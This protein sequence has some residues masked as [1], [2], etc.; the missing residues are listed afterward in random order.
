MTRFWRLVSSISEGE[1]VQRLYIV[2]AMARGR[3]RSTGFEPA[4]FEY[5]IS[6]P[7]FETG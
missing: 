7:G 6:G 5:P 4:V 2:A 3:P 1:Q